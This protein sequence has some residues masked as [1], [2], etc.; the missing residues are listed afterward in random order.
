MTS[1]GTRGEGAATAAPSAFAFYVP[2]KPMTAGSKRAFV[3]PKTGRAII[4]EAGGKEV[5]ERKRTW[6]GDLRMAAADTLEE[7][8]AEMSEAGALA[9][10]F[11]EVRKRPSSHLTTG[12]AAGLVKDWAR[13]LRPATRPDLL[14][15]ARAAEDALTGVLWADDAQIVEERLYKVFGDQVGLSP[16]AEGL[17]VEVREAEGM[18]PAQ[19][20]LVR[21]QAA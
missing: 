19:A 10:T 20:T 12:R 15:V 4:T 11:V 8:G 17:Y 1:T 21:R 5:Q 13:P 2:G 9:V 6:R 14:K 18:N 3:N 7:V 16:R